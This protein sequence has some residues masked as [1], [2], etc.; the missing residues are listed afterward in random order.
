M[1]NFDKIIEEI[2]TYL[3]K[4]NSS[5]ISK[6]TGLPYQTVQ[7]L[8]NGT[9]KLEN[10]RLHTVRELYEYANRPYN[11]EVQFDELGA[12]TDLSAVLEV[13]KVYEDGT[14]ITIDELVNESLNQGENKVEFIEKRLKELGYENFSQI[15][16]V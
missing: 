4:V 12:G 7:D 16:I 10:A 2:Q 15:S 1:V 14:T 13:Q 9:T 5:K 3:K 8:R 6:N 11:V